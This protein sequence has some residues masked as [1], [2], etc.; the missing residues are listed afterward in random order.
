M[1]FRFKKSIGKGAFRL[2]FSKSGV[3]FSVGSKG[4]V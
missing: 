2:N 1:G 3:G 4:L